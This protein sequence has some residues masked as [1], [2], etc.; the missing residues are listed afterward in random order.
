MVVKTKKSSPRPL[1][2]A[3]MLCLGCGTTVEVP[4]DSICTHCG[5]RMV[6]DEKW[7]HKK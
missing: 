5:M 3:K 2:L 1:K 6:K 7:R 4:K